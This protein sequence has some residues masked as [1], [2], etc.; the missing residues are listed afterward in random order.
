M[1]VKLREWD[2][3]LPH[4]NLLF[5]VSHTGFLKRT[6]FSCATYSIKAHFT[7]QQQLALSHTFSVMY[8]LVFTVK[9]IFKDGI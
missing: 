4:F 9:H 1:N 2:D 3:Y 8:E 5:Y 7:Q 6:G